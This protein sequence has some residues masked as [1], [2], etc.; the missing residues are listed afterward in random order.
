MSDKNSTT[1]PKELAELAVGDRLRGKIKKLELYGAFIELGVG[2]EALLHISQ[3]TP[4]VNDVAEVFSVGQ[5]LD[6][7]VLKIHDETKRISLAMQKPPSVSISNLQVGEQLS[8]KVERIERFGAF[9]NIDCERP[10][11]VHVSEITDGYLN[12]P[13]DILNLGQ[14]VDVWVLKVDKR[15]MQVDLTMKEP[16]AL[17]EEDEEEIEELPTTMELAFRRAMHSNTSS[18]A[19]SSNNQKQQQE[20]TREQEAIFARTLRAHDESK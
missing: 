10:G 11:M 18:S 9:V 17:V 13:S 19:K 5:E 8:G 15:K 7:Y 2:A 1:D 20:R 6:V 14:Q 3:I 16:H 12:T 4:R